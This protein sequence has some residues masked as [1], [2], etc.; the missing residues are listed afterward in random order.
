MQSF[1]RYGRI[2]HAFY[3]LEVLVEITYQNRLWADPML[4]RLR[5]SLPYR[6][7]SLVQESEEKGLEDDM[8]REVAQDIVNRL[9]FL[10]T[11]SA[12]GPYLKQ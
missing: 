4:I 2:D 5:R 8:R 1:N 12:G 6:S 7:N 3:T 9:S 11:I 10:S